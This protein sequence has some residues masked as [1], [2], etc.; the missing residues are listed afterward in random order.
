MTSNE[1]VLSRLKQWCFPGGPDLIK[2]AA[3]EI[4]RLEACIRGMSKHAMKA[5]AEETRL[6]AALERI[7]TMDDLLIGNVAR[8]ALGRPTL[9]I[10][11][12]E[13]DAGHRLGSLLRNP[14][15]HAPPGCHCTTHC[16]APV[17]QGRQTP[18]RDPEKAARFTEGKT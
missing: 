2:Q 13:T 16:A 1:S 17:V 9:A 3:D 6:R 7:V 15:P 12:S 8:E 10:P 18:C 11:P 14:L 4:E 5:A